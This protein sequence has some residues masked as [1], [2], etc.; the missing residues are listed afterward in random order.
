MIAIPWFALGFSVFAAFL[1]QALPDD[2][3]ER[4]MQGSWVVFY[5][6]FAVSLYLAMSSFDRACRG[7]SMHPV[8][9][10]ALP[11]FLKRRRTGADTRP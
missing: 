1:A 7:R 10:D 4:I 3:F 9:R 5:A 11:E 2:P 6:T 8:S